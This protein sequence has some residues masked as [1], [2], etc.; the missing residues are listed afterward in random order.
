MRKANAE[1]EEIERTALFP[2]DISQCSLDNAMDLLKISSADSPLEKN[3]TDKK[4][5]CEQLFS[6][7]PPQI[8][9]KSL[10]TVGCQTSDLIRIFDS[11][12]SLPSISDEFFW[13]TIR[14]NVD[15]NNKKIMKGKMVQAGDGNI[16]LDIELLLALFPDEKPSDLSHILEMVGLN[17]AVT[18]LKE[19]NG[20]MNI[21]TPIGKVCFFLQF[22]LIDSQ[23]KRKW[24]V[25][26]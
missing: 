17:N 3:V 6:L 9:K 25:N 21:C 23:V 2:S 10:R 20:N 12:D 1:K 5:T 22:F 14:D 16:L 8:S 19:M 15:L 7:I 26:F 24:R 18:L 13:E 4:K 11:S